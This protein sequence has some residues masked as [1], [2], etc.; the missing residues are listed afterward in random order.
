MTTVGGLIPLSGRRQFNNYTKIVID[1]MFG[2][3]FSTVGHA[4]EKHH[5][6][7]GLVQEQ[8]IQDPISGE[9]ATVHL[10]P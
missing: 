5:K 8:E 6:K 2:H 1:V 9:G 7:Y 4:K 10:H 3:I